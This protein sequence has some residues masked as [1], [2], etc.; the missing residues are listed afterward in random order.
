MSREGFALVA[1]VAPVLCVAAAA[2]ACGRGATSASPALSRD[3][4]VPDV[5]VAE[6]APPEEPRATDLWTRAL[7]GDADDLARLAAYVGSD[8]LLDALTA[9]TRRLAALRALAF[10]EDF[11]A[12]PSLARVATTG[13]DGESTAALDSISALAAAPRRAT[14]P[15]DALEVREGCSL[16][17]M[18]ARDASRPA[19]RRTLAVSALRMLASRGWV[20]A[21]EVPTDL[22]AR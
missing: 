14:D 22:D 13:S 11:T 20:A 17:L 3:A 2:A 16:L 9:P 5:A 18:L 10:A 15:E 7:D 19:P 1:L 6:A 8:G 4:G 21:A 12:L